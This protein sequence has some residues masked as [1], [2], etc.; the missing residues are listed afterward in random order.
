MIPTKY[1]GMT[2][3]ELSDVISQMVSRTEGGRHY[4]IKPWDFAELLQEIKNRLNDYDELV[5]KFKST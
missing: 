2:N 3:Q 1:H 4:I 5:K